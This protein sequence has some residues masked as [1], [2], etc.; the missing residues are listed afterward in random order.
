MQSPRNCAYW[1]H[2]YDGRCRRCCMHSPRLQFANHHR[3]RLRNWIH[4]NR[5]GHRLYCF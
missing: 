1:I 4:G 2:R 3:I 5:Y